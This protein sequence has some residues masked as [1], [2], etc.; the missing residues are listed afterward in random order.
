MGSGG[1]FGGSP[2]RAEIGLGDA[3]GI[4]SVEVFWPATGKTQRLTGLLRD[5]GY[6]VRED[7]TAAVEIATRSF[8]I[9]TAK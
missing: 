8:K 7:A 2:L 5:R 4:S 3:R 9:K 6:R 1:S